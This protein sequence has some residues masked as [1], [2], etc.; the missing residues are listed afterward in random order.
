MSCSTQVLP[1][2]HSFDMRLTWLKP[3]ARVAGEGMK[4][5][6]G[7]AFFAATVYVMVALPG[8]ID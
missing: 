2:R 8:L 6:G 3:A 4:W 5:L 1:D 7:G